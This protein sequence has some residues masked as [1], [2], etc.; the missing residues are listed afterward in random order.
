MNQPTPPTKF[1]AYYRVSTTAQGESGLG[2]E[3][4]KMAVQAYLAT[5]T[6]AELVAEFTEIESGKKKNRP[7]LTEAIKLCKRQK[8]TLIIAK[9]DRL[10]RNV[11]FVSGLMESRVDFLACDNPHANRL[12]VHMLAAFAEH[13][14]EMISQ[15]TKEGLQ[16]AKA[17][18]V[19]LGG[20]SK[21]LSQKNRQQADSF[22]RGM[23][24][25]IQ[26]IPKER[27]QT[28]AGLTQELNAR[29]IPTAKGGRW[30]R[31]SVYRLLARYSK[32]GVRFI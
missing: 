17:R 15:R 14:R 29:Q 4:Q 8:A 11:H 1:V 19:V 22:A 26:Q 32:L 3:A 18:G 13:E 21:T 25:S 30:H 7:E 10:A 16:A 28:I 6:D 24:E 12:M 20:H 31:Q 9:L 23:A 2:L 5:S 27:R